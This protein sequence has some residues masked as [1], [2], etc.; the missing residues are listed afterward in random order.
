M[1]SMNVGDLAD[2]R[3]AVP[4]LDKPKKGD[5][6]TCPHCGKK[7]LLLPDLGGRPDPICPNCGPNQV[8][9][10]AR[11][12]FIA[13]RAPKNGA[14]PEL[15]TETTDA[16]SVPSVVNSKGQK[17]AKTAPELPSEAYYGLP[18]RVMRAIAPHTESH[19]AGIL[20]SFLAGGGCLIGPRPYVYRDGQ[21]HACNEFVLLVG[22]TG[23]GRKGSSSRRI[24]E[25][26][27]YIGNIDSTKFLSHDMREDEQSG[28]TWRDIILRGLGS[29][30]GL[31]A[32]LAEEEEDGEKE[33]RRMVFEQEFA[34]CLK[35][36]AREG[37]TLSEVLKAAWDS[38]PVHVRTKGSFLRADNSH[39]S[40]LA[41]VTEADLTARLSQAD[42]FNGFANRFLFLGTA[43]ARSLPFGGGEAPLAP[44]VSRMREALLFLR[45][46]KMEFDEDAAWLWESVSKGGCGIYDLLSQTSPGLLGA[47]TDRA[48]AHVTRI[49]LQYAVWDLSRMIEIPH[50]LAAL[51]V[52]D[53]SEKT[54]AALFG[55]STGDPIADTILE[56]LQEVHPGWLTRK[57]IRDLFHRNAAPGRI[58]TA[59]DLLEEEGL[60]DRRKE[61]TEGRFSEII[62]LNDLGINDRRDRSPLE[63]AREHAEE[64][65]FT[66]E[67]TEGTGT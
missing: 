41:H 5:A 14:G 4:D 35:V 45:T 15:T 26:F 60:V 67:T 6:G 27:K 57:E 53:Y 21:R 28:M 20:G 46:G 37:S 29:G 42:L 11:A 51:A 47:V 65:G 40:I 39:V 7:T 43:R 62:V 24:D 48:A 50:L 32:A 63:I 2:W 18:G 22:K 64:R 49:A 59:L 44:L 38:E 10:S 34:R 56:R 55:R 17:P 33:P 30:E 58:P 9:D 1:Q 19:D 31:V 36:M 8:R 66:T 52:W 54:A 16:P 23:S 13:A 61:P 12:A 3:I 25:L